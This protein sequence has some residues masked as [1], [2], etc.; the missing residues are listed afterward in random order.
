MTKQAHGRLKVGITYQ[1]HLWRI[2][3]SHFAFPADSRR[4]PDNGPSAKSNLLQ[5]DTVVVYG[6]WWLGASTPRAKMSHGTTHNIA[7]IWY[8]VSM[9]YDLIREILLQCSTLCKQ[10]LN[11]VRTNIVRKYAHSPNS[12]T[13]WFEKVYDIAAWRYYD[14]C[15]TSDFKHTRVWDYE[16]IC[17]SPHEQPTQ[18]Q[19]S[20]RF[21]INS[22]QPL[23]ETW[24]TA[25]PVCEELQ[26]NRP[27][28]IL[29]ANPELLTAPVYLTSQRLNLGAYWHFK[30]V[31]M[32]LTMMR[33]TQ[34]LYLLF[35]SGR[36]M[37]YFAFC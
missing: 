7:V 26:H 3:E 12:I 9:S 20:G 5:L 17:V 14:L 23:A 24:K 2:V 27:S 18:H 10:H 28:G 29:K 4:A 1:T 8:P 25:L 13:L 34:D 19:N 31:K 33:R 35:M 22:S 21:Q 11:V 37:L 30:F 6:P 16:Y 32:R 36:H 15:W